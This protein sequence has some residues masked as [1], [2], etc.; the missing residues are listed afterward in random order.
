M[1]YN[2]NLKIMNTKVKTLAV[3][4]AATSIV[5]FNSCKKDNDEE[6]IAKPQITLTEVGLNNSKIG[7]PG[8]DFHLEAEIVAEGKINTVKVEIHPEGTGTWEFDTTYT[9]FSGLKNATFHKH[10]D[11]P[12]TADTGNYHL[13]FIVIDMLGNETIAET[14]MEIQQPTDAVPPVVTITSAPSANQIF[15]NGQTISVSGSVSDDIA[16]GGMY[17]GLVR[18]DQGLTDADV[19]DGNTITLLHNHDFPNPTSHSFSASLIV[20]VAM[21]N[22]ITPK[23]ITWAQGDY[24]ILVK[25]KDAFGGNWTFSSHYTIIINY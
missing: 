22:N 11:I 1:S 7:Y 10:I 2:Y 16:L 12:V 9:E 24:Y 4:L 19:N 6:P 14:E 17:I 18:V 5:F 3:I 21:D 8:S 20:G 23:P 13:H 25:C 15:T